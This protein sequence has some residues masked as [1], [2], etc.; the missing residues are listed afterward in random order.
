MI[1]K[2]NLVSYV[3]FLLLLKFFILLKEYVMRWINYNTSQEE[4]MIHN[5]AAKHEKLRK[6]IEF[7]KIKK[8]RFGIFFYIKSDEMK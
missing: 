1:S 7:I 6:K 3:R 2:K 5:N 4:N 8:I